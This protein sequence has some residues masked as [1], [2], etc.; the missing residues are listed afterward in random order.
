MPMHFLGLQGMPRRIAIWPTLGSTRPDWA[1]WNLV[2][3][4]GAFL[5][6]FAVL[7]F[8]INFTISIRGGLR[9][10]ADPWRGNTLEWATSSPPPAHNFDLV[11]PVRSSRPMREVRAGVAGAAR[12][13]H[14]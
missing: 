13:E 5:I 1:T 14:S 11:P 2:A 3:T 6:A 10:P 7:L 9:A 12:S 8:L 4:V